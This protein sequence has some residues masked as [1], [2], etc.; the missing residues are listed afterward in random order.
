MFTA[1]IITLPPFFFMIV[2]FGGGILSLRKNIDQ[3]GDSSINRTLFLTSK[4]SAVILWV[5]MILQIWGIHISIVEV[6]T[7]LF[8][9]SIPLWFFGFTLLFL[10]RFKLGNSFRLGTPKES[11]SFMTNGL[12][13][14]SRNPMYLGLY[15]T[16]L[17]SSLY[18]LNP[19]VVLIAAF[20]ISVHHKI[21][22]GRRNTCK[23]CL[24]ENIWIIVVMSDGISSKLQ[25][26]N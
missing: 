16:V 6:P 15:S 25:M 2:L 5:A 22:L 3:D 21:V 1:I 26:G 13:R 19:V 7:F 11:T 17:A 4:W 24:G 18:T 12:Y 14:F 10:G 8:W 23:E 9:I 20:V